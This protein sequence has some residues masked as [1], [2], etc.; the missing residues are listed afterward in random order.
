MRPHRKMGMADR[1]NNFPALSEA[2]G[3]IV[4]FQDR[5]E[6]RFRHPSHGVVKMIMKYV[7]F[8]A[9]SFR[10]WRLSF[11]IERELEYFSESYDPSNASHVLSIAF[12]SR[13]DAAQLKE[14]MA[15]RRMLSQCRSVGTV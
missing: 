4:F 14:S 13:D 3:D 5:C 11:R 12:G 15:W 1:L 10:N 8:V 7:D 9:L 6:Y 2:I